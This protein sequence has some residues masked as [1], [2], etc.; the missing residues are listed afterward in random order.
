MEYLN[1]FI[2]CCYYLTI[3]ETASPWEPVVVHEKVCTLYICTTLMLIQD[4][5]GDRLFGRGSADDKASI[6]RVRRRELRVLELTRLPFRQ[7]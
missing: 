1:P 4:Q 3:L 2:I 6:A 5:G 7:E